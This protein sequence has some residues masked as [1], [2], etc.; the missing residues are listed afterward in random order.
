[1][2]RQHSLTGWKV[3]G[4]LVNESY[5]AAFEYAVHNLDSERPLADTRCKGFE[6]LLVDSG[7]TQKANS[8]T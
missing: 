4:L 7:G 3:C 2:E 6:N 1:M 8:S 5:V